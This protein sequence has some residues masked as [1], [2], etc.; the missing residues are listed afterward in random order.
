MAEAARDVIDWKRHSQLRNR[1]AQ[2]REAGGACHGATIVSVA[3]P[4]VAATT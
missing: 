4:R 2:T 1:Y 3:L